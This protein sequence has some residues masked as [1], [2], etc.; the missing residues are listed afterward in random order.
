MKD[1][2]RA[3][4]VLSFHLFITSHFAILFDDDTIISEEEDRVAA[5]L[6]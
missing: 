5:L 6:Y 1:E 4:A 3:S 2:G